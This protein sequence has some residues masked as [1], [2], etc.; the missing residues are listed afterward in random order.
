MAYIFWPPPP[1]CEWGKNDLE[2]INE[3]LIVTLSECEGKK[4]SNL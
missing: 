3:E 4:G 1:Q 2:K